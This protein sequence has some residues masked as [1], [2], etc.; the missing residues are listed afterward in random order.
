MQL[1]FTYRTIGK[2]NFPES[3]SFEPS[4]GAVAFSQATKFKDGV[5]N[6]NGFDVRNRAEKFEPHACVSNG[7]NESLGVRFTQL[8]TTTTD[9]GR[10]TA[11]NCSLSTVDYFTY[12]SSHSSTVLYQSWLFCG[13]STQWPSSGK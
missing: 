11:L 5:S 4:A 7:P 9:N 3:F 8:L 12:L 6:R 1:S 2:A 10:L 13:F